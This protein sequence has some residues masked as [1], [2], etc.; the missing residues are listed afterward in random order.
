MA[1]APQT[2]WL[3]HVLDADTPLYGGGSGIAIRPDKS[4]AAGDSCNTSLLT[5]PAHAGTHVDAPRHFLAQGAAVDD[6][7]ADAWVFSTPGMIRIDAVPG[8][9]IGAQDLA[10]LEDLPAAM[11]LLLIRTGFE[12][13]RGEETYWA[14]GPGLAAAVAGRLSRRFPALQ[15]VGFDFISVSSLLHR[16]QGRQAHKAFLGAGIRIFEDLSFSA[17]PPG[18]VPAAVV[19]LPLRVRSGDGAP[20]SVIGF[21]RPAGFPPCR[22]E[23]P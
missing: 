12:S 22:Q 19:A 20:V 7:P 8:Q 13:F 9:L 18:A 1:V 23:R 11:D 5:L 10:G 15:A 14:R 4:M 2:V 17:L 16:E 6:Y 21:L 3:S